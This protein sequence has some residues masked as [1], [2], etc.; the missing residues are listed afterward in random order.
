MDDET[1]LVSEFCQWCFG[2]HC[3]MCCYVIVLLLAHLKISKEGLLI[4]YELVVTVFNP[5]AK[6]SAVQYL[7]HNLFTTYSTITHIHP[8]K[9]TNRCQQSCQARQVNRLAKL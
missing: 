8:H 7:T 9:Q 6:Q 4:I 2:C 5:S 3:H 1:P